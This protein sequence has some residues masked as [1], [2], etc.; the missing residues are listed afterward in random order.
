MPQYNQPFGAPTPVGGQAKDPTAQPFSAQPLGAQVGNWVNQAAANMP[1]L[2]HAIAPNGQFPLN[3]AAAAPV[4]GQP[5][6]M[7][8]V[9]APPSTM[10]GPLGTNPAVPYTDIAPVH[11]LGTPNPEG[12]MNQEG[13]DNQHEPYGH[14]A[15]RM[16]NNPDYRARMQERFNNFQS[17]FQAHH[18]GQAL[19]NHWAQLQ[20]LFG[21]P[22]APVAPVVP[23]VV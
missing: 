22:A 11:P 4:P 19:P 13:S 5:V 9:A 16:A 20:S 2:Q 15:D 10:P 8:P 12:F 1:A 17:R 23:P 3:P 14:L 21:Q 6:P 18:P 7:P